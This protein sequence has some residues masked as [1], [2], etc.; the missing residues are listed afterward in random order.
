[1]G[2]ANNDPNNVPSDPAP[3][4][5]G[6]LPGYKFDMGHQ[7]T[8]RVVD[9]LE[10]MMKTVKNSAGDAWMLVSSAQQIICT[11]LGYEDAVELE[12]GV[13]QHN[14]A[15]MSCCRT[16]AITHAH[17]H[18]HAH[19]H[20]RK[21]D[22]QK[23][24]CKRPHKAAVHCGKPMSI[25]PK[26]Q[27]LTRVI[28]CR[29]RMRSEGRL[30][31]LSRHCHTSRSRPRFDTVPH[32]DQTKPGHS[33]SPGTLGREDPSLQFRAIMVDLARCLGNF[34]AGGNH[35]CGHGAKC[36]PRTFICIP[37]HLAVFSTRVKL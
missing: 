30:K 20:S 18:K 26:C 8:D 19:T 15:L 13:P 9:E 3:K 28:L 22:T 12:V 37:P 33:L 7:E 16:A 2:D 4:T 5:I 27:F 11:D 17:A 10:Q 21:T 6:T 35:P 24:A 25:H 34:A 23:S 31:L 32:I 14:F 29:S 1:M 36:M